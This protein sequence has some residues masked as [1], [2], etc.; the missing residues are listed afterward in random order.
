MHKPIVVYR[1]RLVWLAFRWCIVG[2]FTGVVSSFLG[3]AYYISAIT[4]VRI[5]E[6]V[7]E[8]AARDYSV[9]RI[10]F[11]LP[12]LPRAE[13]WCHLVVDHTKHGWALRC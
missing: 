11:E 6:P 9:T 7:V 12:A 5:A 8:R 10:P 1:S 4:Q 2:V 3:A 13:A